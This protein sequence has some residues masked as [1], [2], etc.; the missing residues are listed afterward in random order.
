MEELFPKY[1]QR[2]GY[3]WQKGGTMV[4]MTCD[5]DPLLG[6]TCCLQ[7]LPQLNELS[8]ATNKL[9]TKLSSLKQEFYKK[10]GGHQ[11]A[12]GLAGCLWLKVTHEVVVKLSPGPAVSSEGSTV[13]GGFARSIS[14]L[15][16]VVPKSLTKWAS[17]EDSLT[18]WQLTSAEWVFQ[19]KV[20]EEPS[21]EVISFPGQPTYADWTMHR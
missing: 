7:G 14:K 17:L 16:D 9:P 19:E 4:D 20:G 1:T 10:S 6:R 21:P 13:F 18:T 11:S 8:I 12:Y 15:T 5:P 3:K 2:S